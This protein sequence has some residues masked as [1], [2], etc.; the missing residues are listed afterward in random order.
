MMLLQVLAAQDA[1]ATAGGEDQAKGA[2]LS[3]FKSAAK[4]SIMMARF[5]PP[6]TPPPP[7]LL[8]V[9]PLS[10]SVCRKT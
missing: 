2:G 9:V 8:Y 10:V 1:A 4:T 7:S 6:S 5:G 3:M